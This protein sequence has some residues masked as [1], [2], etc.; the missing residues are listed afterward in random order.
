MT[1]IIDLNPY[2]ISQEEYDTSTDEALQYAKTCHDQWRFYNPENILITL[3]VE[4]KCRTTVVY[5]FWM[6]RVPI[7]NKTTY[8]KLQMTYFG[9]AILATGWDMS[10]YYSGLII[11]MGL[12]LQQPY[13]YVLK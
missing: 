7:G 10:V 13:E 6:L 5:E 1:T 2:C 3:N 9:L 4:Y 8:I 12:Q 11:G